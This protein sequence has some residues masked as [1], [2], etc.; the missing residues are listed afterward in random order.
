MPLTAVGTLLLGACSSVGHVIDSYRSQIWAEWCW[1]MDSDTL[2][3]P[4]LRPLAE[5]DTFVWHIPDSLEAQADMAF[6]YG[7]KGT[8]PEEGYPLFLY[9]HGSGPRDEEWEAGWQLGCLFADSPSV[10]VIPRMPNEDL[11]R[12]QTRGKQWAWERL[13][14]KVFASGQVDPARLYIVGISEGGYGGQRMASFYA[15]YLA[16]AGPMAGGEPLIGAPP[17]N[18]GGTAFSLL[19]GER[20]IMFMRNALTQATGAALDSL[21]ALYPGRYIHRVEL[22]PNHGHAIDYRRTTPWLAQHRREARPQAFIWENF[23]IDGRKRNSF[24]NLEVVAEDTAATRVCYDYSKEGNTITLHA[25]AVRYETTFKDPWWG[26]DMYFRRTLTPTHHGHVRIY[27]HEEDTDLRRPITVVMGDRRL[28]CMPQVSVDIL[29]R[30]C[31]LWC[32][33]LRLYPACIDVKW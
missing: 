15:D 10:Y 27:L 18:L 2:P 28:R 9:L 25:D 20:D 33:P 21:E 8:R 30:S 19:T 12:W 17:E 13:L 5:G 7:N 4:F 11:Y 14:A 3:L 24:Y 31:R 22:E 6:R 26:I 29:R 16:G 32:D 1:A 23:E